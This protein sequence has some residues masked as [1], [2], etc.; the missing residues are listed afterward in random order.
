MDGI[1]LS[2]TEYRK[3]PWKNGKGM[4]SEIHIQPT[5][6]KF[7]SDDFDWRISS[8]VLRAPGNFSSFPGYRRVLSVW[9]GVG[10][11]FE[12]Q[13]FGPFDPFYF[14][15]KNEIF[16]EPLEGEVTDLGVIFRPDKFRV[17]M[18][19]LEIEPNSSPK[20]L[21]SDFAE[22]FLFC[23]LG[24]FEVGGTRVKLGDTYRLKTP[25][26]IVITSNELAKIFSVKIMQI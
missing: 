2:A 8:A 11:K 16:C 20:A 5:T 26:D 22:S 25:T 12:G 24:E 1:L 10:V 3:S 13:F 4:T 14:D 18:E 19:V 17:T 23:G 7:P 9:Q 15:G 21:S 6:S